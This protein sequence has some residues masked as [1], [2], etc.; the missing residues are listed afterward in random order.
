MTSA[1]TASQVTCPSCGEKHDGVT[2]YVLNAGA[3]YAVYFAD[4]YP[5]E[6]E[7]RLPVP[8]KSSPRARSDHT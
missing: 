1:S 7:D 4:W 6:N 8:P 5:H 2:G 3:Q